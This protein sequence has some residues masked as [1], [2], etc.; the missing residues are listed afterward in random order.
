[1]E[2]HHPVVSMDGGQNHDGNTEGLVENEPAVIKHLISVAE[3]GNFFGI[4]E[5]INENQISQDALKSPEVKAALGRGLVKYLQ[6]YVNLDST[7]ISDLDIPD[8][9]L[10]LPEVADA[11]QKCILRF[12]K[13][14]QMMAAKKVFADF[15]IPD[16]FIGSSEAQ[17]A[18]KIGVEACR[19]HGEQGRIPAK[20]II[21]KFNL[22]KALIWWRN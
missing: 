17:E 11:A 19:M 22:P 4:N 5:M 12:I 10:A 15:Y 14:G 7:D 6:G 18:A 16:D 8:D 1:M 20:E 21:D 13:Q 3:A 2:I 9:V